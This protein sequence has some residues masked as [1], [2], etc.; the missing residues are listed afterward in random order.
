MLGMD[1]V[2]RESPQMPKSH[3]RMSLSLAAWTLLVVAALAPTVALADFTQSIE[4]LMTDVEANHVTL[5]YDYGLDTT[6]TLSYTSQI[7][8]DGSVSFASN[9]GSIYL[10]QAF[11]L[12]G[13]ATYDGLTD[14]YS[15]S[16]SGSIGGQT[17]T[18]V[19]QVTVQGTSNGDRI[20][21]LNQ[22][23]F[24]SLIKT[25]D[26]HITT[27]YRVGPPATSSDLGYRT[28][29]NGLEVP[30]S[31]FTSSDHINPDGSWQNDSVTPG[32]PPG[33]LPGVSIDNGGRNDPING[34]GVFQV[35]FRVIPEPSSFAL[36]GLGGFAVLCRRFRS[37]S[38]VAT[39]S[40][41]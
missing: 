22:N 2:E 29:R 27:T 25:G 18:T 15:L 36:L 31:R 30:N 1:G 20:V 34:N 26:V 40:P 3:R 38:R 32:P 12:T 33:I 4:V 9:A 13:T 23:T 39:D 14:T 6:T 35:V 19:G 7:S 5:P 8:P 16:S 28:D 24:V 11:S 10:G 41:S 37:H 21:V 17:W